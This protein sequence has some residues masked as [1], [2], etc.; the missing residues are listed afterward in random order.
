[1]RKC[2]LMAVALLAFC[3]PLRVFAG[4][5]SVKPSQGEPQEPPWQ[6]FLD[7]H[8]I[9][10][11]TGFQRVLHHPQPRGIVLEGDHTWEK[12]GVTPLLRR[13]TQG[14]PPRVLLPGAWTPW[15]RHRLCCQQR[16]IALGETHLKPGGYPTRKGEQPRTL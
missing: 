11:S 6:L 9:A 5:V 15:T 12:T 7:D 4:L 13:S 8:A 14:R 1:M 3:C 10:R 2:L 16:W